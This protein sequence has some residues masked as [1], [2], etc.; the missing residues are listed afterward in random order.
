MAAA[1]VPAEQTQPVVAPP[2]QFRSLG[3]TWALFLLFGGFSAH[4]FYLG[5][6]GKALLRLFTLQYVGVAVFID[7]FTLNKQVRAANAEVAS[8]VRA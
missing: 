6:T 4:Q 3:V 1:P 5:S 8:G 7:L 2:L